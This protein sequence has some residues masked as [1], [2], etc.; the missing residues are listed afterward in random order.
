MKWEIILK[1]YS[2]SAY[3]TGLLIFYIKCSGI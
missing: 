3:A 2:K 1:V